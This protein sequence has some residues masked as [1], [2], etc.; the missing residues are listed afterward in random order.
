MIK[1]ETLKYLILMTLLQSLSH[2]RIV[3]ALTI[4]QRRNIWFLFGTTVGGENT[5]APGRFY[6]LRDDN[7]M[8]NGATL[9]EDS[10]SIKD[11]TAGAP[12]GSRG[13]YVLLGRGERVI[14]SPNVF[15]GT[16]LFT[17]LTPDRGGCGGAGG[18]ARLYAIAAW[19]GQAAIDFATGGA[20]G[21][22]TPTSRRSKDIGRGIASAPL[23]ITTRPLV[24]GT[25][26]ASFVMTS[27]ANREI[28]ITAIPAPA[29]L[30]HVKSWRE[31]VE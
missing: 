20:L 26:P 13:W 22:P 27:T 17:T 4:D 29:F 15:N 11:V 12:S 25:P 1:H 8:S 18:A 9:T 21:T 5:S 3:P 6:A 30:K 23:V 31:R 7:D 28:S 19:N 16:V 2:A 24:P 14:G 10:A